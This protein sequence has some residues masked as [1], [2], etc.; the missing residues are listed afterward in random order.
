[1][2]TLLEAV[3]GA[4]FWVFQVVVWPLRGMD[5]LW[6][7]LVVSALAGLLMIWGFAV[8]SNQNAIR[9]SKDG[10]RGNLLGV[11][12]FQHDVGVVLKLQAA[13]LRETLRYLKCSLAPVAVLLIPILLILVQMNLLFSLRP[14]RVG[15]TSIL[16]AE[17]L[18]GSILDASLE[19]EESSA[20]TLES[21]AMRVPARSEVSWRIRAEKEGVHTLGFLVDGERFEKTLA[22]G[23][24]WTA[25]SPVRTSDW[26]DLFLYSGEKSF[27]AQ[28][29]VRS[30]R[31][32]YAPLAV[33]FLGFQTDW[34]VL[35]IVLSIVVAFALKGVLGVEL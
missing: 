34:L 13:I 27:S 18:G 9:R 29:R 5:P 8:T 30:I 14:L 12:L 3:N 15:E 1:M 32:S 21:P 20:F 10:I 22:V 25:V 2:T 28:D 19:L 24:S 33:T 16:T 6:P 23:D 17:V 7:I 4:V 26:L 11:R 31:L 35:F